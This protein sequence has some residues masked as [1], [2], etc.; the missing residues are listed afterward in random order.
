MVISL[1]CHCSARQ[2]TKMVWIMKEVWTRTLHEVNQV[3]TL[4][5]LQGKIL[6]KTKHH[7]P[8]ELALPESV[9]RITITPNPSR[10]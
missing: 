4:K 1:D 10:Q 5:E 6:V 9:A 7:P 2:Q 3:P 8:E